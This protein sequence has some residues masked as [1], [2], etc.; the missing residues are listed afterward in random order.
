MKKSEKSLCIVVPK[1]RAEEVIKFLDKLGLRKKELKP[2]KENEFVLVPIVSKNEEIK[3]LGFEIKSEVFEAHK[4][5]AK[6]LKEAL[7]EVLSEDEIKNVISSY[8]VIGDIA[9]LQ[10]P[11]MLKEK[12]RV[13]AEVLLQNNPKI[14]T[15]LKKEAPVGGIFRVPKLKF[16]AG[17]KKFETLHKESGCIFKVDISKVFFTPRLQNERMR[18]AKLIGENEIIAAL[19]AGV[20]PF[21]IVFAKHSP[22]KKAYA[23]EINPAAYKLLVENIKLNKA[24]EKIKPILGDV[25][26]KVS[27][28]KGKCHRVVMPMPKSSETFFKEGLECLKKEGV[29][30]FY[31]F[32]EREKPFEIAE[33]LKKIAKE[34]GYKIKI[35]YKAK[36]REF[37]PKIIQI[38]LDLYAKKEKSLN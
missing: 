6:S 12:E 35:L 4:K 2:K 25:R 18:I 22:M 23:I 20:G 27:L 7:K 15:V 32:V 29:I 8:D 13:I 34:N 38:V 16:L 28:I 37:S 1:K 26:E 10:I 19:F 14:K 36:V 31:H 33:T 3:K 17:E 5:T 30:H 21:P 24:E 9:I 11:K